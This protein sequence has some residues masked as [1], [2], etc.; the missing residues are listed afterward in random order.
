MSIERDTGLVRAPHLRLGAA[1]LSGLDAYD[2]LGEPTRSLVVSC[3][4]AALE[5]RELL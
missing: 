4:R 2:G 1:H 5:T 3:L